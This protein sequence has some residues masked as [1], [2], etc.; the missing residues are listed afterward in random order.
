MKKKL[1][2]PPPVVADQAKAL[3]AAVAELAALKPKLAEAEGKVLTLSAASKPP[4]VEVVEGFAETDIDGL[5]VCVDRGAITPAVCAG[6]KELMIGTKGKR[7]IMLFSRAA[8]EGGETARYTRRVIE[9][10]K[11]N[12][13][14]PPGTRTGVQELSAAA[15][16]G[17]EKPSDKNEMLDVAKE[18]FGRKP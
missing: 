12:K 13:P 2:G 14:I 9:I 11:D 5:Q 6:L 10:L 15:G 18:M 7:S 1:E 3:S 17:K 4:D 16:A 8:V